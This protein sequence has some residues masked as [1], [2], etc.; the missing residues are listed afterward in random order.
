MRL[1]SYP[2]KSTARTAEFD[3][4]FSVSARADAC[5]FLGLGCPESLE[6]SASERGGMPSDELRLGVSFNSD[7]KDNT[8]PA[9]SRF[10]TRRRNSREKVIGLGS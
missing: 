10:F 4:M 8:Q 9:A 5:A 1:A 6:S 7:T 2:A 3:E